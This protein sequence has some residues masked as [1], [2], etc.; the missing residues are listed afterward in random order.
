MKVYSIKIITYQIK[1][2]STIDVSTFPK[3]EHCNFTYLFSEYSQWQIMIGFKYVKHLIIIINL[4][5]DGT[6]RLNQE[7][8]Y[9]VSCGTQ[10]RMYSS[11]LFTTL[12]II[13]RQQNKQYKYQHHFFNPWGTYRLYY[14]S[15]QTSYTKSV[16]MQLLME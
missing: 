4:F 15:C 10:E 13:R 9:Y 6:I 16:N 14:T 7:G 5:G 1:I 3:F 12:K 2:Y 11:S 8:K